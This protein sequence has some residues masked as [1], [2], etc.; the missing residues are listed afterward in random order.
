MSPFFAHVGVFW[1][2]L[3]VSVAGET[4]ISVHTAAGDATSLLPVISKL[5]F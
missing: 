4:C 3:G 1:S 2:V 5:K